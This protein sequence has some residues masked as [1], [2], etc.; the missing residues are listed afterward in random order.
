MTEPK[1]DLGRVVAT[2]AALA[3]IREAGQAAGDLLGRHRAGDWGD[4]NAD[5]ARLNDD[6]LADGGRLL[7]AY[8][9]RTGT[10]LWV[11]TEAV[12]DDDRRPSTCLLLPDEY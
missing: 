7:S 11:I 3:A 1:F 5:D 2:P 10:K 9:L 8:R 12:G 6:A 4:L